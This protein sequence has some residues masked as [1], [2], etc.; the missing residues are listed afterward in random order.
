M[1]WHLWDHTADIGIQA[2]G[3]DPGE[4]LAHAAHALT[5]IMTGT[6]ASLRGGEA[7]SFF[8]EAP[9]LQSLAV[10]YLSELLWFF[11]QDRRLWTSGGAVVS[12]TNDGW[13]VDAAGNFIHMDAAHAGVEIKAVT[14]HQLF[15]GRDGKNWKL[16][17]V[18]DI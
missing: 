18:L 2:D 5:S 10:A 12:Q 15:F 1:G 17:I 6:D 16:R 11:E 8:V 7:G 14:Y 4:T 13:R 9:D 3:A